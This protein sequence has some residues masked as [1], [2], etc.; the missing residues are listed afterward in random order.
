M[1]AFISY[2]HTDK[3]LAAWVKS[4]LVSFGIDVFLAHEDIEPSREW[5]EEILRQLR[6][7]ELFVPILTP[8]FDSSSWTDQETG[9]AL[10]RE[11]LIIPLSA[12]EIPHGFV[13]KYQAFPLKNL[14]DPIGFRTRIVEI[15]ARNPTTRKELLNLLIEIFGNSNS[16]DEAGLNMDWLIK[17]KKYLTGKERNRIV[18]LAASNEQIHYSFR[19]RKNLT[20]FLDEYR[21]KL[22]PSLVKDLEEKMRQ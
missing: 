14:K 15:L 10:C 21:D 12:G 18:E 13:N 17:C 20:V 19:A 3:V 11:I 9:F 8:G 22:Q 7:C 16:F 6:I 1:R 5:Q 4:Q 2:S